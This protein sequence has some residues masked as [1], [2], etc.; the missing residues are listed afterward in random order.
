MKPRAKRKS[1]AIN[2]DDFEK[3]LPVVKPKIELKNKFIMCP[4]VPLK[5]PPDVIT[6]NIIKNKS[7]PLL[8]PSLKSLDNSKTWAD[9]VAHLVS[10]ER[11]KPVLIH[12][13]VGVGKTLGVQECLRLC[14]INCSLVDGS[15]PEHPYELENWIS[16]VRDNQVLE[17]NGSA[18]FIDDIES[19]TIPCKEKIEK[20][21]KI[22]KKSK[23]TIIVT[24]TDFYSM[25]LK[26]F[27]SL[28]RNHVVLRL[29][30]PRPETVSKWLQTKGYNTT[31]LNSTIKN[32]NGDLR[33]CEIT[34]KF[35]MYCKNFMKE[36]GVDL[37]LG[38]SNIDKKQNIFNLGNSLLT[39][40]NEDWFDIYISQGDSSHVSNI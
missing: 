17:G 14:N 21:I 39:K 10:D 7:V 33:N 40:K 30:S 20:H 24:C 36:K 16:H 9:L 6:P 32:F 27:T 4:K 38:K 26:E 5:L 2:D 15:A 22:C 18:L 8:S 34:L 37:K 28:F 35:H 25:H 11:H 19:F 31:T 3:S 23:A 12:G 1:G 29:Y 13:G